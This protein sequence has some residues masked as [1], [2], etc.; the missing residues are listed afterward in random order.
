M[1]LPC[2]VYP[3]SST[4]TIEDI[5]SILFL[6]LLVP[7]AQND[8]RNR[9]S[10]SMRPISFPFMRQFQKLRRLSQKP[11]KL[12]ANRSP[13]TKKPRGSIASSGAIAILI[14]AGAKLNIIKF[15][16]S[17]LTRGL[18]HARM[19]T[20]NPRPVGMGSIPKGHS[21]G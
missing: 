20:G 18:H 15:T 9:I 11:D 21:A 1:G 13:E 4:G 3:R 8:T 17:T 14:Q 2:V 19:R 7:R 5:N 16:G 10:M 12:I 6:M